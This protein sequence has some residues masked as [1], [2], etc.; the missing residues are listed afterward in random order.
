MDNGLSGMGHAGYG[1]ITVEVYYG[2][3]ITGEVGIFENDPSRT[4]DFRGNN[5]G[6]TKLWVWNKMG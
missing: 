2:Y 3:G 5:N 1:W 4:G 6:Q